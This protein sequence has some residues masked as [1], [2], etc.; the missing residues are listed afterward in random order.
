M[1]CLCQEAML[2]SASYHELPVMY[3]YEVVQIALTFSH[4]VVATQ[5]TIDGLIAAFMLR[6]NI[7]LQE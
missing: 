3:V 2:S 6:K 4:T 7:H 5:D 1:L